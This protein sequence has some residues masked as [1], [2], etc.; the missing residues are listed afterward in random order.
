MD[1][2]A[3]NVIHRHYLTRRIREPLLQ[4]HFLARVDIA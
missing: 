4:R 1:G 3:R 2:L